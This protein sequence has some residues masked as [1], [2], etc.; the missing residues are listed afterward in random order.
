MP[1]HTPSTTVFVSPNTIGFEKRNKFTTGR[2]YNNPTK[3][4]NIPLT[5]GGYCLNNSGIGGRA[6]LVKHNLFC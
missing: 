5:S 2:F 4:T 3:T 1:R 6:G